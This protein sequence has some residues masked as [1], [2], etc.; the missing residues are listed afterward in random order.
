MNILAIGC[1]PDDLEIGCGGTLALYAK[2]GHNV[3][4]CHVANGDKGHAVIM[5]DELGKLRTLEAEA[6]GATLGAI[7]S[8]LAIF[9]FGLCS[10][11]FFLLQNSCM[12]LRPTSHASAFSEAP[13]A[14]SVLKGVTSGPAGGGQPFPNRNPF[15]GMNYCIALYGIFPTQN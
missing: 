2:N 1:H 3:Y 7:K 8:S 4:M 15:L 6:S 10:L 14:G 13:A 5:P 9:S 11:Y 12:V